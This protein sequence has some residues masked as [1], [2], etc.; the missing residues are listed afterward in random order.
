MSITKQEVLLRRFFQFFFYVLVTI[1]AAS[2]A[3]AQTLSEMAGQMVMVGFQGATVDDP[4]FETVRAQMAEGQIGGVLYLRRNV[5]S[6]EDVR[7]MNAELMAASRDFVPLI[8]LDQEGGQIRRLTS[9]VG[10]DEIASAEAIGLGSVADARAIYADLAERLAALGF[11]VNLGPVVDLNLNPDNPIIARYE[12]A[13]G[14]DPDRVTDF[15]TAFVQGHHAA[16]MATA[17]KHFPGHG[18]STG[19]TH[20]GFVDVSNDWQ[21]SELVPFRNLIDA[22]L[23]DMVMAAHVV[24][25]DYVQD[26]DEQ[27]PASLSP[28][29]IEG[30]LRGDLGYDGVVISDD[31]QMGAVSDHFDLQETV[32]RA[33]MAGNDILIFS[34][35]PESNADMGMRVH[36]IIVSQAQS[37]PDFAARVKE[38]YRRIVALKT[39]AGM[40]VHEDE[41]V[42]EMEP[43]TPDVSG[44]DAESR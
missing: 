6:L 37:D 44:D 15:G 42:I 29:W 1:G 10:F 35:F 33:V 21:E 4:G 32:V 8:A 9:E 38:S 5:E 17:L 12:R 26:A 43:G 28:A 13:F 40:G 11:T 7:A 31:M 36:E 24:N 41:M 22:G 19:D 39:S 3:Q 30:V 27:L 14:V 2:G 23:A 18:S 20:E 16:G 25:T 34:N